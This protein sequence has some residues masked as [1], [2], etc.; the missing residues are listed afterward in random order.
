MLYN[1]SMNHDPVMTLTNLRHDQLVSPVQML[2][3]EKTSGNGQMDKI[4][5]IL[6]KKLTA[7]VILTLPW[8]YICVYAHYSQTNVLVHKRTCHHL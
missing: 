3:K 1:A 4:L 2:L 8:D 7:L 5:M 6:K